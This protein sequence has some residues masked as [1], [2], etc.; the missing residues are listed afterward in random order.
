M[1]YRGPLYRGPLYR[2][3]NCGPLCCRC[4]S[5]GPLMA[6]IST[7]AVS[8]RR[9]RPSLGHLLQPR[10]CLGRMMVALRMTAS[11]SLSA[12]ESIRRRTCSPPKAF[13]LK[14]SAA[15][16]LRHRECSP[17][18]VFAAESVRPKSARRLDL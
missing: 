5:W 13:A 7:A 14:A 18:N 3:R 2:R 15:E 9:S 16:S 12:A 1:L 6:A 11:M 8:L 17:P 10:T 4:W